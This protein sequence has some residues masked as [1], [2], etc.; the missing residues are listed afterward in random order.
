MWPCDESRTTQQ[1]SQLL[2]S[3]LYFIE[4]PRLSL[5]TATGAQLG[6][7][8]PRIRSK[9]PLPGPWV[10]GSGVPAVVQ[11]SSSDVRAPSPAG[12]DEAHF[13]S[14]ES[15]RRPPP[16]HSSRRRALRDR[17]RRQLPSE[18]KAGESF[19]ATVAD[20]LTAAAHRWVENERSGGLRR[21]MDLV[22]SLLG[23]ACRAARLHDGGSSTRNLESVN[24]RAT[25]ASVST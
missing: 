13:S 11:A 18:A 16:T 15:G 3:V 14:L 7:K 22:E 5:E 19:G 21:V 10:A 23:R 4:C 1:L 12:A 8:D 24:I 6:D 17:R 2:F 25:L 20:T 9:R